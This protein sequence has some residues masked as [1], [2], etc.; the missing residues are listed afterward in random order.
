MRY[1]TTLRSFKYDLWMKWIFCTF[2][3]KHGLKKKKTHQFQVKQ[4]S[5]LHLKYILQFEFFPFFC[6]S[7]LSLFNTDSYCVSRYNRKE[8]KWER[9]K[10]MPINE[11]K[12]NEMK[13]WSDLHKQWAEWMNEWK[14]E[15][16]FIS[17]VC[18]LASGEPRRRRNFAWHEFN[19]NVLHFVAYNVCI[20][21][22]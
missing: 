22:D 19:F 4:I 1:S 2:I 9:Q 6:K 8:F 7:D 3:S 10:E 12:W 16:S 14:N 13:R 21:W 17:I 15:M 20:F 11:I 5:L 18:V